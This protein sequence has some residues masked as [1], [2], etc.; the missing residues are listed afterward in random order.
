MDSPGNAGTGPGDVLVED[1]QHF[2]VKGM[3]WGEHLARVEAA[4]TFTK[5]VSPD[6]QKARSGLAKPTPTKQT[7]NRAIAKVGGLHNISDHDLKL[8][9]N[10]LDM[11]KRYSAILQEDRQKR[12]DGGKAVLKVLGEV[13]KIALPIILG[14]VAG[15]A[16][17][18]GFKSGGN[19]FKTPVINGRVI[20]SVARV[21]HK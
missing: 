19:T 20:E 9:L 6:I 10:R 7:H 14:A 1:L 2:G 21:L 5:K 12:I 4:K 13:G 16:A 11:E 15:K 17:S 18:G 8:M 3:H